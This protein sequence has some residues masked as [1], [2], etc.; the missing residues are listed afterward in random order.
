MVAVIKTGHSIHR[1]LNYNENKVKQGVAEC[2]GAGNYPVDPDKMSFTMKLNRFLKQMELNEKTKRN[3]V[4]IS[5]NFDVS[6]K[7]L[8]KQK[9]LEIANGYLDKIGFGEQPYLVYQHHDAGHPHIHLVTTNIEADGKRIDLHHLG[10]RKSE[11]ARKALE[12]EFGLVQAEAQ[13]KDEN[14]QLKPIVVGKAMYGKSQTKMAIQN[15][16]ENVLNPYK[17]TSLPELNAVLNQ[18]NVKAERGTENSKVYQTGGLLYRVLDADGNAVGVPIKASLFYNK[19]TLKFLEQKFKENATKRTPFK[20]RIKNAVDKKLLSKKISIPELIS[21]LEKQGIHTV[22]R[23]NANGI[24]YGITYV[25]HQTKCV[26]NGSVL[27]K[28][29]SAKAIQERCLPERVSGQDLLRHPDPKQTI[30]LQPQTAAAAETKEVDKE[31]QS[32]SIL[33]GKENVLE[34]LTQAENTSNYLPNQL[35][36]KRKKKKKRNLNNNQ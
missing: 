20:R 4:H 32:V 1:I 22:L 31:Y 12:K 9:L 33:T 6:E 8:P 3:S 26:F 5:L 19:P 28:A 2:I 17:Y 13:K 35:K 27:G 34:V 18:Y 15:I 11:P 30:G 7:H 23:Q 25:D 14:Y 10:I 21:A 29:Y 24:L 16:L 36:K